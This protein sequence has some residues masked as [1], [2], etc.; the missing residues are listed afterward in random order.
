MTMTM[1]RTTRAAI[2]AGAVVGGWAAAAPAQTGL[3]EPRLVEAR[4]IWD[5]AP[6]NA[7]TDLVRFKDRWYCVFREGQGHVSPDGALRVI[8]SDDGERWE[9]AALITSPD[10]DLRD[11]KISVTP[12]GRLMLCGAEALHDKSRKSHQ[13]LAWFS[14]D[15]VHW[16]ERQEIGDPDIWLWRVSWHQ[17]RG[18][19]IGYAVGSGPRSVRLYATDDGVRF[20]P[21]VDRLIADNYPNETSIVFDGPRALCLLRRDGEANTGLFGTAEPPYT[22]WDW[23]DLGVRIGGPHMIRLDDGRLVAAVRLYDGGARTSLC[24]ID[25]AAATLTEFL[26]LPSGGDTSYAGLAMHDGLLWVSY[27]SSHEGKTSIYLAKVALPPAP[28]DLGSRRELFVDDVLID[29]SSGW[30]RVL[31]RPRPQEVA[32]VCDA[33]WEGNTSAYYTIF[34]DDDRFRMYYRGSHWDAATKA[35]AHPEVTCY[36]ESRDGITWTKPILGLHEFAGSKENNIVWAGDS[37]HNFTPFKDTRPDC[38]PEARYKALAGSAIRWQGEGLIAFASPDGIHWSRWRQEPVI[39]DGD[40]DSQNLAFWDSERGEYLAYVRKFRD[41]RIRDIMVASS[42]DFLHWTEPRS[43]DY[44]DAP[45]EQLYTNAIQPYANAPHLLVGFPT[46]FQ[47]ASEQVEPIF[48]VSR[49]GRRFLRYPEALIPIDAPEDRDGNRS[50]Y[51]T[52]GMV[53]TPSRPG[54]I[55][56]Y[57]T[58]AYYAGPGSR[59]RRFTFRTDGFVALHAD[60]AEAEFVTHPLTFTG[61]RLHVNVAAGD[62]PGLRVELQDEAGEPLPGFTLEECRPLVG[63]G[64]D[65]VVSWASA[66]RLG[67]LAGRPVRLRFVGRDVDLFAIRFAAAGSP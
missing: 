14:A 11:A 58:E 4:R 28:L 40:F 20:E 51:M 60:A 3:V 29:R 63:D 66:A 59:V 26:R 64:L 56:V 54:E 55:S 52:S 62:G 37:T 25:P 19:G 48:M 7:F 50:N 65:A 45:E 15:G 44:G 9:S 53:M 30:R 23:K 18:L 49:D 42:P 32:L 1:G 43:L 41:G 61:D 17:G 21:V 2:L 12:D 13:T 6:H 47:P 5:A 33:P 22:D 39:T 57:A 35:P 8:V 46:R 16:S 38:P 31:Q 67:D 36:A 24:W 10:S 27:Y 34:A